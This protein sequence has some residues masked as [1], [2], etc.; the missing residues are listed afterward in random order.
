MRI[1]LYKIFM[2]MTIAFLASDFYCCTAEIY[3]ANVEK[4]N[5]QLSSDEAVQINDHF[6]PSSYPDFTSYLADIWVGS[7]LF[8]TIIEDYG[9]KTNVS[10]GSLFHAIH[11]IYPMENENKKSWGQI[12]VGGQKGFIADVQYAASIPQFEA[13]YSPDASGGQGTIIV[14]ITAYTGDKKKIEDV[15]K[16][17]QIRRLAGSSKTI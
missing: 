7:D 5:I 12:E 10:E 15:M 16:T 1:G 17:L 6:A 14:A 2:L 4:F 3:S 13:V 11:I 8:E 9:A